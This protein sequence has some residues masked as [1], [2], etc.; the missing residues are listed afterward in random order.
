[1]T[2]T[3]HTKTTTVRLSGAEGVVTAAAH[4]LGFPPTES[5]VLVCMTKE[6]GRVG[7][8]IR[9]DLA[10][11][12]SPAVLDNLADTV[13]EY[14]DHA[15]V[16][17]YHDAASL[18]PLAGI[19]RAL[20]KV[21]VPISYQL[22]V[23]RG[24]IREASSAGVY[25]RD[26]G[27]AVPT[28]G[29]SQFDTLAAAA[30]LVGKGLLPDREALAASITPESTKE[31]RLVSGIKRALRNFP[32]RGLARDAELS[33]EQSV[34]VDETWAA[35]AAQYQ[36]QGFMTSG[37][38]APV[39]AMMQ[40][41]PCRDQILARSL[42][43]GESD[44]VAVLTSL[45]AQC[46]DRYAPELCSVLAAAAYRFGDGALA[47]CALDRA[48]AG[49][50]DHRLSFLLRATIENRLHPSTLASLGDRPIPADSVTATR[51][52]PPREA[53]PPQS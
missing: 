5:L 26:R 35:A 39:I 27:V 11:L 47:N 44:R 36:E 3:E 20:A 46:P 40:V 32:M 8:V 19:R 25:R 15:A 45:A 13:A 2:T 10:A 21:A 30:A 48:L 38:A 28:T 34:L 29:D 41:I 42:R 14:A 16:I 1:M 33:V 24:R 31:Q 9:I 50:P 53:D 6:R 12:R 52:T 49:R 22:S 51:T 4:L 7:P 18:P 17:V 37:A 23:S 43:E